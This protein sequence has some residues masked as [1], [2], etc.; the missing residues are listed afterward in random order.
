[1][2]QIVGDNL[3]GFNLPHKRPFDNISTYG[4]HDMLVQHSYPFH[5]GRYQG[6]PQVRG[7]RR[8]GL[9]GRGY[10]RPQVELSRHEAWHE[11][12]V[13]LKKEHTP[14]VA[15]K[16]H[17]KPKLE[18]KGRLITNPKR[19]FKCNGVRLIAINCPTKRTL[20]FSEDL[21][22][23]IKK[24]EDDC[25]EGIVDKE[26]SRS[27]AKMTKTE[28]SATKNR[29]TINSRSLAQ[30]HRQERTLP[31]TVRLDLPLAVGPGWQ[32]S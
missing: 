15:F 18:E 16:D 4:Y 10:Y 23:W 13:W 5:E 1:M 14:N 31:W 2:E 25:P 12:N 30:E 7:G 9:G 24:S 26:E 8:G 27:G 22:G 17:S 6:R 32:G 11:E 21:N 3:G 20:V 28:V 29:P 19:S